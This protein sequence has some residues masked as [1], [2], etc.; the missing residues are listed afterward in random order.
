MCCHHRPMFPSEIMREFCTNSATLRSIRCTCKDFA[1]ITTP[2]RWDVAYAFIK[3]DRVHVRALNQ[4]PSP[5]GVYC[6]YAV[7]TDDQP[8]QFLHNDYI[9]CMHV[10]ARELA[11]MDMPAVIPYSVRF[12]TMD[13]I[14]G[15]RSGVLWNKINLH[16]NIYTGT[17]APNSYII[18]GTADK[19]GPILAEIRPGIHTLTVYT[20]RAVADFYTR[21]RGVPISI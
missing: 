13:Q 15:D 8:R 14:P 5:S 21:A 2:H 1:A 16:R 10:C 7:V 6:R 11:A 9:S 17:R 3:Y 12:M 20:L 18:A 4:F 19:L